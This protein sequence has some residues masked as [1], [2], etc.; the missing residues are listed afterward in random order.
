MDTFK[1][2]A[3]LAAAETGSL[4]RAAEQFSYTPSAFSHMLSAFEDELG[5][6]IFHRS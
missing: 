1:I 2:R 6:R 5:V 3:V 4:S